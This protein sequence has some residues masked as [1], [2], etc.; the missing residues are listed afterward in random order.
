ME[1]QTLKHRLLY[2]KTF[3]GGLLCLVLAVV[4]IPGLWGSF[5]LDDQKFIFDNPRVQTLED[6]P[7][8]AS[9]F[10]YLRGWVQISFA[11]D[12]AMFNGSPMGMHIT[13]ILMHILTTLMVWV[14]A[15][16]LFKMFNP[17]KH[18]SISYFSAGFLSAAYF[19]LHPI[20]TQPVTHLISRA[21]IM[22]T[23]IYLVGGWLCL[24]LLEKNE[25]NL[26]FSGKN[27]FRYSG[28]ILISALTVAF[29]LGAKEIIITMP[30]MVLIVILLQWRSV[31]FRKLTI[32]LGWLLIPLVLLFGIYAL[33]RVQ[34]FGD[35]IGI[36]DTQVRSW[37]ENLLTQITVIATYYLPRMLVPIDLRYDPYFPV[38]ESITSVSFIVSALILAAIIVLALVYFRKQPLITFGILWF[39]LTLSPTSSI[40][41]LYDIV[42]ERRV[43]LSSVGFAL[44]FE[45]L[46]IYGLSHRPRF[47]NKF[48]HFLIVY[49]FICFP[50][51][52]LNRNYEFSNP[53][54]FWK[55]EAEASPQKVRPLLHWIQALIMDDR[56][57]EA[58][59]IFKNREEISPRMMLSHL[60]RPD[61]IDFVVRFMLTN[62][63]DIPLAV[64]TAE[65]QAQENPEDL[66][67][68]NTLQ[69]AYL[70]TE[71]YTEAEQ[72][73]D[74]ALALDDTHLLSMLN[75]VYVL[76]LRGENLAAAEWAERTVQNHPKSLDAWQYLA[77]AYETLGRDVT[78][79][80][81]KIEEL[82][83]ELKEKP[84]FDKN[85]YV[86]Q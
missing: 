14:F 13:S 11:L 4:Y 1:P 2:K 55:K 6:I 51:L 45:L 22:A 54:L 67:I 79:I 81:Q 12:W 84:E 30:V 66:Q 65:R 39:L 75:K 26:S 71:R 85:I 56:M 44:I 21:N 60:R 17:G 69:I 19:G 73:I 59:T 16:Q 33:L 37:D 74:Q 62:G 43:Y 48:C 72:V 46:V 32:R 49:I 64:A 42:A 29:G 86:D 61:N 10:Y 27:A 9:N 23:F 5:Y 38:V 50:L 57:K 31:E 52:T 78:P 41:P 3:W 47:V 83:A 36:E 34:Q 35:V 80:Q 7:W 25:G 53:I 20:N 28:V 40:I 70:F 58:I 82:K 63:I 77:T 18:K 15:A 24:K 8:L 68:L 76:S